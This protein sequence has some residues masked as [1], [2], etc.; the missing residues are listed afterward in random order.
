MVVAHTAVCRGVLEKEAARSARRKLHCRR[1]HDL[2]SNTERVGVGLQHPERLRM[3]ILCREERRFFGGEG[4]AHVHGL[5][6]SRGFVQQGGIGEGQARK[7]GDHRLEIQQ[8]FEP[9][10]RDLGLIGGILCIPT[11]IFQNIPLNDGRRDAVVIAH[12]N[13]RA[14][15]LVLR[16]DFPQFAQ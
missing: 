11:R 4:M 12:P 5:G 15:K 13:E 2:E 7:I 9:P 6:G 14:V 1:V 3:T 10:L 16:G 8:R